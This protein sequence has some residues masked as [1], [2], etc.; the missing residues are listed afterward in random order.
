M[1]LDH[2]RDR[3]LFAAALTTLGSCSN[4]PIAAPAAPDAGFDLGVALSADTTAAE[5]TAVAGDTGPTG[6]PAEPIDAG[7]PVVSTADP[8]CALPRCFAAFFAATADCHADFV[9]GCGGDVKG[10]TPGTREVFT[11]PTCWSSGVKAKTTYTLEEDGRVTVVGV[12]MRPDGTSCFT[13]DG[14]EAG[15]IIGEAIFQLT[16]RDASGAVVGTTTQRKDGSTL[17]TCPDESKILPKSCNGPSRLPDCAPG[18]CI[19]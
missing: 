18:T 13:W 4:A 2:R 12:T 10:P 3:I 17:Y 11:A 9:G 19:L 6:S 16:Y 8:A 15:E 1:N 14:A 7:A 5:D